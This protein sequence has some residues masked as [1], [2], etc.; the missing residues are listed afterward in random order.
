VVNALHRAS[1][2]MGN[3]PLTLPQKADT[4]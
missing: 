3:G 1:D 4:P 2:A